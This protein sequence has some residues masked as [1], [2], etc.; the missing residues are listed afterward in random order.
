MKKLLVLLLLFPFFTALTACVSAPKYDIVVSTYVPYDF[1]NTIVEDRLQ[2]GMIL[3][4]GVDAH[5][6]EPTPQNIITINQSLLFF[7]ISDEFEPWAKNALETKNTT[8]KVV[9]ISSQLDFEALEADH[10][11]HTDAFIQKQSILLSDDHHHDHNEDPHYWVD[12][13]IAMAMIDLFLEEIQ[14][15]APEHATFFENNATTLKQQI[16]ALHHE[17]EHYFDEIDEEDRVI[18]HAG[19]VNLAYFAN[20]YHI[21]VI[22]LTE[23]YAPDGQPTAPQIAAM[24]NALQNANASVLFYEE[25]ANN[26]VAVTIQNELAG[27]QHPITLLLFHGIHNV[28]KTDF[29]RGV[30]YIDIMTENLERL[31]LAFPQASMENNHE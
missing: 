25:L 4:P 2:V 7:Y 12:P 15:I 17:I 27:R 29:D 13:I 5:G 16:H 18:Y 10:I 22:S 21:T 14:T 9:D 31:K 3:R 11:H 28:S 24:V 1:I 30:T 23:N 8:T 19:H 6:F 26:S 20:R